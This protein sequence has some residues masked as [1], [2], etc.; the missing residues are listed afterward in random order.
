MSRREI[1]ER[2][3]LGA[4][5]VLCILLALALGLLALD[6]SRS[7]DALVQGDVQY[8][9]TP[10]R[11]DLWRA[12]TRVPQALAVRL[13]GSADDR[14]RVACGVLLSRLDIHPWPSRTDSR[15]AQRGTRSST[16]SSR[17]TLR[18]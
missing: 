1:V 13:I 2:S 17:V 7:R 16:T 10:Q 5:A 15:S 6:V 18:A 14:L 8:R 4:G 11:V 9:V 12:D 3:L